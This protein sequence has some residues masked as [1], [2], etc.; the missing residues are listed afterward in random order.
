M[1]R[2]QRITSWISRLVFGW[3]AV[4]GLGAIVP[5]TASAQFWSSYARNAQHTALTASPSQIPQTIRWST[6][7]HLAPQYN[8][9]N[10]ALYTHYGS[11]VITSRNTVIVPVKTGADGGFMV[12]AFNGT[13]GRLL[14]TMNTDYELPPESSWIQPMG[15]TLLAGDTG[16]A[17]PGAG[18]TILLRATPNSAQGNTTR[19]G[20]ADD[21]IYISTPITS[22]PAGNLYFGYYGNGVPGG[23]GRISK[24]G[25]SSFVTASMLSGDDTMVKVVLNCAPALSP[26]GRRLYVAVNQSDFSQG[27][28]CVANA[29]SLTP[30]KSVLLTDPRNS[31][32]PAALSDEG[33]GTPTIGPDG[34]VYFGVLEANFPSHHARGWLLHFDS[35][36][37]TSKIPGSFGWDDSAALVPAKVVPSYTGGSSYLVLTKYNDYSDPGIGGTGLNKVAVLD[38]NATEPDLVFPQV[39][40]MKEVITVV[41]VTPNNGQAG[42]REWCINT[43]AVDEINQCAIINSE[44]GH[45]YR[46]SFVT[47]TLSP[48]LDLAPA[49][50]EAYTPTAI[51]PDG[52]TYAIND[53]K[54]Y[55]CVA[56]PHV[57]GAAILPGEPEPVRFEPVRWSIR[58]IVPA[59]I[60]MGLLAAAGIGLAIKN[61]TARR[62]R[63]WSSRPRRVTTIPLLIPVEDSR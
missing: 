28:L 54:L 16:V 63:T 55:C 17:V 57:R 20:Q 47:N 37:S 6:P 18:G 10:G 11:P 53:A 35:T 58:P 34:D 41:G 12:N 50:G 15:I 5:T 29:T 36:L 25:T 27:Y 49:T 44:D 7:V 8:P 38:P 52:A 61:P 23:L 56:A 9:N 4:V 31:S 59:M 39:S 1:E 42:V 24:G 60:P 14:W 19:L 51:G 3:I 46:W 21:S 32:E 40:V 62:L 13:T 26:D 30:Q 48:G 2:H 33:S 43:A 22:D 45:V